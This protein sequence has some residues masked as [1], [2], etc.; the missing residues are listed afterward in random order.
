MDIVAGMT[1]VAICRRAFENIID[2]T[3]RTS[4]INMRT[5]QRECGFRV[6]ERCGQPIRGCVAG[7]ALPAKLTLVRVVL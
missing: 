3:L 5:G 2:V 6:V 1:G 7:A 4:H